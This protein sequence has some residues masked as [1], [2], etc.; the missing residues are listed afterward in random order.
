MDTSIDRGTPLGFPGPLRIDRGTPLGFPG[1]LRIDRGTPLGFPGPLRI[2][3]GT[4]LGFPGPLRIDRGTPS[5]PPGPSPTRPDRFLVHR[6]ARAHPRPL[7]AGEL[8][9]AAPPPVAWTGPTATA[10]LQYLV[11]VLGGAGS[12][13]FLF[14]VPGP[15]HPLLVVAV[16]G[17]AV[18]SLALGL[19]LRLVE[20]RAARRARRRERSRYLA[21]LAQVAAAA[22][23]LA[24]HQLAAADHLHPDPPRLWALVCRG[25]RLW[26]RRPADGDFLTVRVGC[27]PVPLAA[28]LRLD[29][30]GGPL[31]ERDPELLAAA[32]ALVRRAGWLP[33]APV[34]VPLRRLGVLAVTGPHDR[35]RALARALLCQLAAVH[36]PDDLRVLAG[37]PPAALPAWEWLKWLPHARDPAAGADGP[38]AC[39]LAETPARLVSLLEREVRPR[40][41]AHAADGS[42]RHPPVADP[43]RPHLVAVLEAAAADRRAVDAPLLDELLDRAAAVGVT[44]LWLGDDPA[45]EPSEPAARLLLD[46]H[47]TATFQDTAPGGRRLD[48][49]RADAAG[50][51]VC[52][53]IAR[54]LAPLRLDRRT[55]ARPAGPVRLLDLLD[56]DHAAG[57]DDGPA[58]RSGAGRDRSALL[59]VPV[60]VR[61]RGEPVVLDLKEAAEGGAGPHGLVVGATG[62]GKSEL[63]RTI[64]AG[65]AATHPPPL[66]AFVLVDFKGGAAFAD[67]AGLPQVAG[68]ITNLQADLSMV[69]RARAA[70]QGEQERRQRL[71]REAGNLPDLR[72][73]AARQAA[74]PALEP[75]PHLLVVVDEFGELLDA[76]PDFLD[77]FMAVGRV[78][79]SLGM[80]L[81]LASQRLDEGRLRGLDGHLRYRV[82]LRTFGAAESAAVLGTA[83]AYHLP[84]APG[85]ALLKVDA[86]PPQRFTA[87]L[88]STERPTVPATGGPPRVVPFMPTGPTPVP[89][90]GAADTTGA[91]SATRVGSDLDLLVAGLA[92]TGAPVHQV[93]L[94][95][96]GAT[97]TVG[98]LAAGR[99]GWLRAT[100]GLVDRPLEQAQEPLVLDFSGAAGHLAVVGA[101]RTGKS[102]LLC[103]IVAALAAAHRPDEVQVYALD[104]GGG[105][106]HRLAGL[107][108]VGAVCGAREPD[109]A[110]RLARE[111][112]TLVAERERRFR[113]LGLDAMAAWHDLRRAGFDLGPYGE[114]FL[115]VDNWGALT[116]ELP[117]LEAGIGELAATGLHYGV[118][119][120]LAANRWADLRPGLR[121]NLGG[122]LELRLNDPLESELGRAAAA[123][124]PA[125]AGR[126]L[127]QAGLQF[128]AALAGPPEAVLARARTAPDG[129]AAP[130]LRL[131]PELV[132]EGALPVATPGRGRRHGVPFAIE[133]QR[134]E[135]VWLDLFQGP[136]HFLVFGDAECGK[137]S[138][139]RLLA[140]GLAARYGPDEVGLLVVD[141]R[142][143]LSDLAGL[144]RLAAYASDADAVAEVIGGLR[145]RLEA[146]LAGRAVAHEPSR[147]P[148]V[149][150]PRQVVLVD[151]YDLL[152][153]ATGG[154]LAPLV[155]LLAHGE[156]LGFH[157]VLA[158]AVAGTARGAFE[159]VLQ[160]LRELGVP[161][162][163]MSGD[164]Q[165][166]P[167]LGGHKAGPLPAGRGLLVRRRRPATLVQVAHVP[168]PG[169][170]RPQPA[171]LAAAGPPHRR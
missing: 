164:P 6:T 163:V 116:R 36:A 165:E 155:D 55:A 83:D 114:V 14:A 170:A 21:H 73:Y 62:S 40:L 169:P 131:L 93:W 154:L 48:A 80:H 17:T 28:P 160:R 122:R 106:L 63:L 110:R 142:R 88:V 150:D 125:V 15:R 107:P 94:P 81:L 7:P 103:T 78:G 39:L 50:L 57:G 45:A 97:L 132:G 100:V 135:P 82:C 113:D 171:G 117:E 168:P 162:L 143:G 84:A 53:A 99:G 112:R 95:P 37:F 9:V 20:R 60:G 38:P 12:L 1:P 109:R 157:L 119:L 138:L 137:T 23:R 124:L 86:A 27:G 41:N 33:R 91:L 49:I 2:D 101:P 89:D 152:P 85:A 123:A 35:V 118:H 96:L 158:R 58:G 19:G 54:R 161:G 140:R 115:V 44:V 167:V 147:P 47:G 121:D 128:Q 127:T 4:P 22:D 32:E 105:L 76:R 52:E 87:A 126:G 68:L 64:V 166:G 77:L 130:P 26:E 79:R 8:P 74:D 69:D 24:A 42:A 30:A 120:V 136:P 25:G 18:A 65:L 144:P 108:H 10:W 104:L 11:P 46:E 51:A 145:E 141:H 70:L 34:A 61:P 98:G 134:L 90:A 133:E 148:S 43:P 16:A 72:A 75:L 92:G 29:A 5:G 151:D 153:A 13:A 159:P 129:A 67:L 149:Q 146:R 56:T 71:L 31:V 66:L 59:R 111:L 139:L 3:R 156:E 102:T